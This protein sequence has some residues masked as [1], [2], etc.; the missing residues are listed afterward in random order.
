ME[1]YLIRAGKLL[2]F[3]FPLL[4]GMTGLWILAGKP[5]Q[6]ALFC[7]VSMYILNYGDTPPN[8][9][10]E[11]ARWLAPLTTA[12]GILMA[13]QNLRNQAYGLLRYFVGDGVAVYGPT[14]ER[15]AV[16]EQLGMRGI[17]GK[18]TP[19]R[20]RQHILLGDDAEHFP[21][22][23]RIL[24]DQPE[25]EVFLQCAG[26]QPQSI[27]P[28]RLHLF[29]AEETA[30]RLFWKEKCLY[31]LSVQHNHH[32]KIMML[33]F[34]TLGENLLYYGLLDNI[35]SP[36]QRI[37]YH[38]FGG[39]SRFSS[40]HTQLDQ[41]NDP[42]QFHD[43]PWW[44]SLEL[45]CAA[46]LVLVLPQQG[47][48]AVVQ[49]LLLAGGTFSIAAFASDPAISLLDGRDG[50]EVFPWPEI[51]LKTEHILQDTL[52][53]QAQK[54]NL[55]YAHI[56][57]QIEETPHNQ[58]AEWARLDAF[59]RYSNISC[60]DYHDIRLKMLDAMGI[61]ADA[62]KLS[63]DVRE[64]LTELEHIRWCRY[65]YLNNWKA[66]MPKNGKR[67]DPKAR[68]HTDLIP[69]A[70]LKCEEKKKD[71]ENIRLLLG[72]ISDTIP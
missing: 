40:V 43:E 56:Y 59:T 53:A 72:V 25:A 21:L 66:G 65:H 48:A 49:D 30:A 62:A 14:S 39:N 69:Y 71:W 7:C 6:D 51:S 29:S 63:P 64:L 41:L 61:P 12:G 67:K 9:L 22:C 55:R 2:C 31:S 35:F 8:L 13:L 38:I 23:R 11:F 57:N 45:L 50:L 47:Q 37:E 24:R 28:P 16:L 5:V 18:D 34:G 27:A 3:F 44:D 33:G 36:D 60:A 20:A 46:Q 19:I 42:V 52:F 32:L 58:K 1:K 26:I 15:D 10:T 70:E 68:I 4:L 17:A 54:I